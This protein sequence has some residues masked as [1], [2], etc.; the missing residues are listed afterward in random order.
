MAG[1]NG[2]KS[3]A[4]KLAEACDEVSGIEKKGVN[5]AQRYKYVKAA[6]VAK[7]LRHKLFSRGIVI[8]P[9][10]ISAEFAEWETRAKPGQ[11]RGSVMREC[12]LKRAF[13]IT[14]GTETLIMHGYGVAADTG[15]KAI[16]KAKTGALKYFLRDL[17]LIPDEK[18]DPEADES[19]DKAVTGKI[20]EAEDAF[21]QR[22]E[23][24]EHLAIFQMREIETRVKKNGITENQ[25]M[26]F[27]GTL[28]VN[29]VEKVK[30]S[31]FQKL[32]Q[33]VSGQMP[34][35]EA[36]KTS[37]VAT[38]RTV[39]SPLAG[40]DNTVSVEGLLGSV[41]Q[42]KKGDK[43]WLSIKMQDGMELSDWHVD[44]ESTLKGYL[45]KKVEFLAKVKG[46]GDKSYYNV[47]SLEIRA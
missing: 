47:D 31:D 26:V 21:D 7:E 2:H 19:V 34:M 16:Y 20:E 33:F 5:E 11:E 10:E 12:R 4:A 38:G 32:F 23:S 25:L 9:D 30:K 6:D 41:A 39:V 15:D 43:T 1:E 27:L 42:R 14:D 13:H 24:D 17:G 3:L 46:S 8:I 29:R 36:L 35:Q 40:E 18:D 28:G 44:H 37:V 22:T 45:G